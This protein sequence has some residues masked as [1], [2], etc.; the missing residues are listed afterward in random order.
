MRHY[1]MTTDEHFEAAVRGEEPS[2]VV[3]PTKAAQKAAQHAHATGRR[4][5]QLA[6]AAHEKAPVLPGL[7]GCCDLSQ[8]PGM[9]GAGFEPTTSRL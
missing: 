5:P 8:L 3:D 6:K 2:T 4:K 9:A 1:L 7:A